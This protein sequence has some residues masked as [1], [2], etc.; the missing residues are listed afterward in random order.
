VKIYGKA[1]KR[2]KTYEAHTAPTRYGMGDYYGRAMKAPMGKM[3]SDSI[4]FRPVTSKK[5]KTPPRGV[6]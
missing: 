6:V 2:G 4:G 5:L 1:P 3:R